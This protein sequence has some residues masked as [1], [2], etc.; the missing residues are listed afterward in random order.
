MVFWA[1]LD[2]YWRFKNIHAPET[3]GME[4]VNSTDSHR[5]EAEGHEA[6][7]RTICVGKDLENE[8]VLVH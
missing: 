2:T 7:T 3:G 6:Q 4:K 5:L 1:G 8:V